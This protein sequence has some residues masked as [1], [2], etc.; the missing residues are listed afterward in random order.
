M[1]DRH[2][3]MVTELTDAELHFIVSGGQT[4][5]EL[6]MKALPPTSPKD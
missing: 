2:E 3:L 6:L 1:I 4:E 5:D